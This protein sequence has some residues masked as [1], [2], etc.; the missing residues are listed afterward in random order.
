M[1]P[2]PIND[3]PLPYRVR[4]GTYYA[5]RDSVTHSL[6]ETGEL[7]DVGKRLPDPKPVPSNPAATIPVNL[8]GANGPAL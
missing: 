4:L 2:E 7:D 6:L 5:L 8:E 3:G 1:S